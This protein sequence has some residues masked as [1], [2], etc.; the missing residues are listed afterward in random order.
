[1]WEL[2]D[3]P[4]EGTQPS[5]EDAVAATELDEVDE[6][7]LELRAE[8]AGE[9]FDWDGES[10][11]RKVEK[12][13]SVLEREA[14]EE[15]PEGNGMRPM[16]D[17]VQWRE[18]EEYLDSPGLQDYFGGGLTT[19]E[20]FHP[21]PEPDFTGEDPVSNLL[22]AIASEGALHDEDD[23]EDEGQ[24]SPEEGPVKLEA[25]DLAPKNGAGDL[26][27]T[28]GVHP[29]VKLELQDLKDKNGML[30]AW[31]VDVSKHD[32]ATMAEQGRLTKLTLKDLKSYLYER[33]LRTV[34]T[35]PELIARI[36]ES[37]AATGA[38]V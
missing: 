27:P 11:K 7:L 30:P 32:F 8:E 2:S 26:G 24:P 9:D 38:G 22:A 12:A 6:R 23:V 1:M 21:E 29:P 33:S 28:N 13:K 31:F 15:W 17:G 4:T 5:L 36:Q 14:W 25:D 35:K 34:G 16:L 37:L 20:E 19:N 10:E 3:L 18:E